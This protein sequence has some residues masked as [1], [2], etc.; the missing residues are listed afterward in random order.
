M[1]RLHSRLCQ[2][3]L[4]DGYSRV[5][6]TVAAITSDRETDIGFTIRFLMGSEGMPQCG[7]VAGGCLTSSCA[8]RD[9]ALILSLGELS[10]P[11]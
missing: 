6:P 11:P 10:P 5:S 1:G 2:G 3:N 8:E 9:F 7:A 4:H